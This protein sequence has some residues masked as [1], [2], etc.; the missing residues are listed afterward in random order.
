MTRTENISKIESKF[1]PLLTKLPNNFFISLY[2][3]QKKKF[4]QRFADDYPN[5]EFAEI[6]T[7]PIKLWDLNFGFP[8]FNSA[9]MF[10]K[11]E[12]YYT[13]AKQGAGAWLAGTAT[14]YQRPGNFK[15]GVLHPFAAFPKS[16][17]SLNWMGLPN[18]G[19][20]VIAARISE[21]VKQPNCPIGIS[22]S[23]DTTCSPEES[24]DLLIKG[25]KLYEDSG[26]DFI[27]INESCP[28]VQDGHEI[29]NDKLDENLIER[30]N[31]ISS[32]YLSNRSKQIPVILKLSVDTSED[33]IEPVIKLLIDLGFD[34]LNIGNTSTEYNKVLEEISP[35]EKK[36]F[37]HFKDTFGGGIS[38]R[39]LKERSLK[40]SKIGVET[41]NRINPDH[42]FHIIRTGGI[43][44][45]E[46]LLESIN[47]GI[48]L[49]QW[50][51][52]YFSQ[53]A[54]FGHQVYSSL[55]KE[56]SKHK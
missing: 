30:L 24:I 12:A 31:I 23:S 44:N 29:I 7:E 28:N 45:I 41:I 13:V 46:D 1:R 37:N 54:K 34:G 17:S 50:Y 56:L 27:E 19:H 48:Q 18:E 40:L 15:N 49:N 11:A 14:S 35:S 42:E 25:L 16:A 20:D 39:P 47:S 22:V 3:N 36:L 32:E 4:I 26:V 43:E 55:S 52:G 10:K 33:L 21:I 2:S 6:H 51:T 9:G 38:G 8:L 53:F 5:F